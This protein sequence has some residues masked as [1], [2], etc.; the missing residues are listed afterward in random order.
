MS[1]VLVCMFAVAAPCPSM[2]SVIHQL[3]ASS[4]TAEAKKRGR[5][6]GGGTCLQGPQLI[7]VHQLP[8]PLHLLPQLQVL[9]CDTQG[10]EVG[11]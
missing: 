2:P 5:Q 11:G 3:R 1:F 7:L 10:Q 4:G 9:G 6:Q 8:Q